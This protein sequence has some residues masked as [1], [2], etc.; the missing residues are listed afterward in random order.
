[1][2]IKA[3]NFRIGLFVLAG[4]LLFIGGLFAM[5]LKSYFGRQEVFETYVP[6]QVDNLSVG[7]L[8]KLRGVTIGKVSRIDFVGADYPQYKEQY[9]LV[10]FE[11]PKGTPWIAEAPDVQ[12]MLDVEVARGLRARV[13]GQGF[14]GANIVSLEYVDLKLYPVEPV[15]WKPR[16]YYIPSAPNQFTRVLNSMEK[17]LRH[18]E[19]LDASELLDRAKVLIGAATNLLEKI[20]QVDFDAVGTNANALIVEFRETNR[21]IQRTLADA[22]TAINGA[23]L[24]AIGRDT[25]ALEEKLA[26]AVT[27]LRRLLTSVNTDELNSSLAN[28]R[29]ATDE[30]TVLLHK[31]QQQP[32]SVLFSK[33]PQPAPQMEKPS[34][35]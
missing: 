12:Q 22:Q 27:D 13:Q 31:L 30:L 3:H 6:G 2:S 8:V 32:S 35:K 11:I 1:M 28:V 14:L 17:T 18:L 24:P 20:A 23:D 15:P 7:A 9:V 34:K 26:N 29:A 10:Q 16:H 33:P 21:G 5:G 19:D 4:A 25:T